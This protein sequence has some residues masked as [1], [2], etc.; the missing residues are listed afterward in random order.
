ML[1]SFGSLFALCY[2][3]FRALRLR[4][5]LTVI[6]RQALRG[7]KRSAVR[8]RSHRLLLPSASSLQSSPQLLLTRSTGLFL[9]PPPMR[10]RS[11]AKSRPSRSRSRNLRQLLLPALAF[12]SAFNPVAGFWRLPCSKQLVMERAG[13]SCAKEEEGSA[14]A[15]G[16]QEQEGGAGEGLYIEYAAR[17][18]H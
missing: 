14:R 13:T 7:P 16:E 11:S 2:L 12:S 8:R 18:C 4:T 5:S 15:R 1:F 17:N 6:T 9:L 10:S 3:M